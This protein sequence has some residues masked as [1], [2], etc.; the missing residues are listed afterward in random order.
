MLKGSDAIVLAADDP[1]VVG[2]VTGISDGVV[3]AS[4]PLLEVLPAYR[5]KGIGSELMR[6]MLEKLRH[7]YGV[8]LVCDAE[9]QPFYQRFGLRPYTAMIYRNYTAQSGVSDSSG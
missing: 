9:L 1:N 4:I 8:D 6:R 3:T 2:F 5:G 7:L